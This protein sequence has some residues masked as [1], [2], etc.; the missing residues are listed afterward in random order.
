MFQRPLVNRIWYASLQ[1]ILQVL[2]VLLHGVRRTGVENIPTA[3]SVLLLANHQSHYDPPLIG[4][5]CPRQM[6]YLARSGLFDFAP[7]GW[8]IRSVGAFP[9]DNERSGIGGIKETLRWLKHGEVVLMFPEGSR[10]AD[11]QIAPFRPGFAALAYRSNVTIVPVAVHGVYDAWPRW[12]RFPGPGRLSVRFGK[13]LSPEEVRRYDEKDLVR[14]VERRVRQCHAE[15][16]AMAAGRPP[17]D[18]LA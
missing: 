15:L 2:W 5:C 10:T 3:G 4:S 13:P 6:N 11:G 7:F 9:I 17:S 1:R 18:S 14:E 16:V 8:L 12:R